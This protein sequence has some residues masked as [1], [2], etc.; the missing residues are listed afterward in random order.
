MVGIQRCSWESQGFAEPL[1]LLLWPGQSTRNGVNS[2]PGWLPDSI[3]HFLHAERPM[4]EYSPY[5]GSDPGT[6]WLS[7]GA[8]LVSMAAPAIG[9]R[10]GPV[11]GLIGGLIGGAVNGWALNEIGGESGIGSV[12]THAA[13]GA[14]GG[15]VGGW[16]GR[17]H[18][19]EAKHA[20]RWL[21][22]LP[23]DKFEE[24]TYKMVPP[25]GGYTIAQGIGMIG[26]VALS[27]DG[28]F[29]SA[30]PTVSIGRGD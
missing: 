20:A 7:I 19:R 11:G 12:L 15:A 2:G 24:L 30:L 18:L 8:S 13:L 10:W 23:P 26:R 22:R 25:V 16:V 14:A 28:P 1:D 17:G 4:S 5:P 3:R 21:E 27:D 6:P 29:P 9:G